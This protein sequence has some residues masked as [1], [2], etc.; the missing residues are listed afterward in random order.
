MANITTTA[1]N[2]LAAFRRARN[3]PIVL[4]LAAGPERKSEKKIKQISF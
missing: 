4:E 3:W 1:T 2:I